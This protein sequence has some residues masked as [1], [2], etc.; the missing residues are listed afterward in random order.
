MEK[1]YRTSVARV[2]RENLRHNVRLLRRLAGEMNFFCPMVKA[3]AY[4]H[5]DIETARVLLDEGVDNLGVALIEEGIRLREAGVT[6][7]RILVFHPHMTDEAAE[8]VL[9][10]ELTPVVSSFATLGVL[11]KRAIQRPVKIHLKFNTGMSRL[12]FSPHEVERLVSYLK[13]ASVFQV[14]GLCSH[15]LAGEDLGTEGS[16]T[17]NQLKVLA[18]IVKKFSGL[19]VPV[20]MLNSCALI[21]QASLFPA[22][23][24]MLGVRP[25]LS[26][27]GVKP[28]I[29]TPDAQAQDRWSEISFKP[30][31]QV[32]SAVAHVQHIRKGETVSYGGRFCAEKDSTIGVVAFGYADGYSRH[33]SNIGAMLCGGREVQVSG[34]VCMDFTMVDLTE[35]MAPDSGW[36][37]EK[38]VILGQQK[39]KEISAERMARTINTN[40]YEI[41]TSISRRVPR[42]YI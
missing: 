32:E 14:D 30:V 5:G 33:F 24:V 23:Q 12:G 10:Y 21:A 20:H 15:L 9:R 4:G 3:D 28:E 38:V 8:A 41:L 35:I 31:M 7:P 6:A 18:D 25:G 42:I 13:N 39:S 27:Y 29:L 1:I 37:G 40:P 2:S 34:T 17:D 11:E 22:A 16:R 19:K 36:I 26:L